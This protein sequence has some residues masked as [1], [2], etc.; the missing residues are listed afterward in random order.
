MAAASDDAA[1]VADI[2]SEIDANLRAVSKS[3]GRGE[4]RAL[5]AENRVLRKEARQR[6][7]GITD[8]VL[9]AADVV[10][11]GP[12]KTSL[13][14]ELRRELEA[15]KPGASKLAEPTAGLPTFEKRTRD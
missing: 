6:E 13:E 12:K 15:A 1:L 7:A 2:R 5:Y 3:K 4:A 9:A 8:A 10:L 11:R 14:E